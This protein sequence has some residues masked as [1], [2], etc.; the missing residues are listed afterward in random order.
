[1]ASNLVDPF[2]R[3]AA[4]RSWPVHVARASRSTHRIKTVLDLRWRFELVVLWWYSI[5]N[6]KNLAA[7]A[8]F[9]LSWCFSSCVPLLLEKRPMC[10]APPSGLW[11]PVLDS[12][13]VFRWLEEAIHARTGVEPRCWHE[14]EYEWRELARPQT[15]G[16][17]TD[18]HHGQEEDW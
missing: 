3:Q 11:N 17:D 1:M 15:P 9:C 18:G 12:S 6:A 13:G 10:H 14:P 2:E 5:C 7:S 16:T 4:A 8:C